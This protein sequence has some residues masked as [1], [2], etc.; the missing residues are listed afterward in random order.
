[1]TTTLPVLPTTINAASL[2]ILAQALN[3]AVADLP[4]MIDDFKN[5]KFGDLTTVGVEDVLIISSMY[6]V[7]GT[8]IAATLAPYVFAAIAAANDGINHVP[9]SELVVDL[10]A[11]NT[12]LGLIITALNTGQY[13]QA[14]VMGIDDLLTIAGAFGGGPITTAARVVLSIAFYVAENGTPINF[15][16][17]LNV[18]TG[19]LI[20][21]LEGKPIRNPDYPNYV[22]SPVW[23]WVYK[24]IVGAL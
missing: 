17:I 16:A 5:K 6:G 3:I 20:S 10:T 12:N 22:W 15:V 24:P 21:E 4:R 18:D 13:V 19:E 2:G 7:P 11:A 1:M 9:L 14:G 8:S 23:G